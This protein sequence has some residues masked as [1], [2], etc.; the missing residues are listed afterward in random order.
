MKK[1]VFA[2]MIA[3]L[4]LVLAAIPVSAK[5][6]AIKGEVTGITGN[7][8]TVV[9]VRDQVINVTAPVDFD[10]STLFIG[11][12]VIVKGETQADGSM[13]AEWV[14]SVGRG[15][16]EDENAPE[17]SKSANSAY[18]AGKNKQ[19]PHPMATAISE[20]YGITTDLVMEYFCEGYSMGAILLALKTQEINGADANSLLTQRADGQGWGAIWQGLKLIGNERDVQTPPG[21]LHKP[22]KDN[23]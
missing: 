22:E 1:P 9:T 3:V 8:I 11:D 20:D 12:T 5:S 17:G 4:V 2:S 19:H 23:P 10:V 18:C 16:S 6:P 14:K 15:S 13:I 21:W 7:V